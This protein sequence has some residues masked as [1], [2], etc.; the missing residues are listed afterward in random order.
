MDKEVKPFNWGILGGFWLQLG[1]K[2]SF[3]L[4]FFEKGY[5]IV[6]VC[7]QATLIWGCL[8]NEKNHFSKIKTLGLIIRDAYRRKIEKSIYTSYEL[9]NEEGQKGLR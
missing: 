1:I 6:C 3:N 9:I 7:A 2:T 8:L 4:I 5:I